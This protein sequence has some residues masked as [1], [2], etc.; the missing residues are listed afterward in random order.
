MELPLHMQMFELPFKAVHIQ[1]LD[2]E[3]MPIRGAFASGVI[4]R[5]GGKHFLY[6]CWHVVTGFNMHDLTIGNQLPNRSSLRITIQNSEDRQ[7]GLT[8]V[9][10]NQSLV[11]PLYESNCPPFK[12]L[13]FQDKQEVPQPDLNAIGLRV[14]FWHDAIKIPLP[15]DLSVSDM[16][17]VD[18]NRCFEYML[19]P[20]DKLFVVGFPYGYSALG[21]DQ[22]TP[23]VLTR[24]VAATRVHGRQQEILL[25]S[26]GAS[27]MSGGPV[28]IQAPGGVFLVGLYTGLVYPDHVIERNDRVTALGTCC[29]MA[30]CWKHL[31]LE[32]YSHAHG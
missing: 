6:T 14:P 9:G 12:P 15:D 29:H 28:F 19:N 2:H 18:E 31:S 20:G 27:C 32:P 3:G 30:L 26:T 24:H 5:E 4:R 21:M 10:G 11:V 17:V 23:I 25:D 7:P 13:W 16:Q 1:C 8:V 22:P